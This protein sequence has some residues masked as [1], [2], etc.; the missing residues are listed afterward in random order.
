MPVVP[1]GC[2]DTCAG[3]LIDPEVSQIDRYL[4][5]PS[6]D[7]L[8]IRFVIDTHTHADHFPA[9]RQIADR[10]GA[11]TVVHL[12]SPAPGVD[13]H[14]DDGASIVPGKLRLQVLHTPGHNAD[15]MCLVG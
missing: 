7:A 13:M 5:L 8:R 1:V 3:A 2:L 14:V 9:V 15:S 4:A 12:A 6:R 11:M 10:L